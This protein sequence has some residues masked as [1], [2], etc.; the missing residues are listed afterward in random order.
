[1]IR[2]AFLFGVLVFVA[3]PAIVFTVEHA[4]GR[5]QLAARLAELQD[6]GEILDIGRLVPPPVP[7]A[8]N[9]LNALLLAST[10][11]EKSS[12]VLPPALTVVAP[13]R[14]VSGIAVDSW[15]EGSRTVTWAEVERWTTDHAEDLDALRAALEYPARRARLDWDQGWHMLLPHLAKYKSAVL[16]LAV[17]AAAAARR[18][19]AEAAAADLR[20]MGVLERDLEADPLLIGHLVRIACSAIAN[21]RL[22]GVVHARDWTE[23]QLAL[24]QDALPPSRLGSGVVRALEGE[25]A[26]V[27]QELRRRSPAEIFG[28]QANMALFGTPGPSSGVQAPESIEQA[29]E[30]AGGFA[31]DLARSLR[32]KV[33]LPLWHFAWSDQAIVH[34]LDCMDRVLQ[35]QRDAVRRD[36]LA[37][38]KALDLRSLTSPPTFSGRLRRPYAA[39]LIPSLERGL[40]LAL[41]T[42]TERTL[43]HTGIALRRHQ[44]RH[45]RL[46]DK[47]A[48]L[49]P[50]FLPSIPLDHQVGRP[51]Q[52]RRD[53]AE[54]FTLWGT[55]EDLEDNGGDP[56]PTQPPTSNLQWWRAR[57]AVWP[58][59]ASEEQTV[60]WKQ[61]EERRR[62]SRARGEVSPGGFRMSTELMKR[63]GLL[64]PTNANLVD[65][66]TSSGSSRTSAPTG[67]AAP[68]P[69]MSPELMRRYGLTPVEPAATSAPAAT[70]PPSL[71][72]VTPRAGP[73]GTPPGEKVFDPVAIGAA[74]GQLSSVP[75]A[76]RV[77]PVK[78]RLQFADRIEV[79]QRRPADAQETVG[80]EIG[81]QRGERVAEQ[82][83]FAPD[84]ELH[85]VA[86][87]LD[88]VDL[89]RPEKNHAA[90]DLDGEPFA[91]PVLPLQLGEQGEQLTPTRG[92]GSRAEPLAQD[93]ESLRKP[94]PVHRLEQIID[95][96]DLEGLEREPIVGGH[97]HHRR[98]RLG[99]HLPAHPESVEARHLDVEEHQ[100]GP[101]PADELDRLPAVGG[102]ADHGE[103]GF[104]FQQLPQA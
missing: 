100:V 27:L 82:V 69:T 46:P 37:E 20:A 95:R 75:Q 35:V 26:V 101:I 66:G 60:A 2:R 86:L 80:R 65:P 83:G 93:P 30:T 59:R 76:H 70:P 73:S 21:A 41:R 92:R 62:N 42:D 39:M 71:T 63:Y 49:V 98:H 74:Q 47:L 68:A 55:G 4:R 38:V 48:E 15:T 84:V 102:L 64:P 43:H 58:L 14:A 50:E 33:V 24:L 97:E 29:V 54:S 36:S 53:S 25:R 77:V 94:V 87:R 67:A 61:E 12:Q 40:S 45:G 22:W 5:R 8:S 6:R 1:M 88:P 96:V 19:D 3:L 89:G 11:L 90:V 104:L 99:P 44:L 103:P 23:P 18:G 10:A 85:V 17:S 16:S 91:R 13:A 79:D 9:G 28:L 57:D 34:Y 52:Y 32:A 31:R 7:P 56:T 51:L 72:P 78:Q 81:L